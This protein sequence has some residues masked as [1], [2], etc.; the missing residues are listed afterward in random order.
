MTM[1]NGRPKLRSRDQFANDWKWV[2]TPAGRQAEILGLKG[3]CEQD[4]KGTTVIIEHFS[5]D[6]YPST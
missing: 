3:S 4:E 2:Q 5:P 6:A 1:M